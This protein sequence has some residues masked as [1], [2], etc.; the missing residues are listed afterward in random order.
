MLQRIT[1]VFRRDKHGALKIVHIHNSMPFDA[2]KSDELF[3]MTTAKEAF[4]RLQEQLSRQNRQI[5]LMLS[6]LPGGLMICRSDEHFTTK[7]LSPGLYRLLGYKS[8]EEYGEA[9]SGCCRGFI[10]PEDYDLMWNQVTQALAH[11]DSYS[12]E[13]RVRRKDGSVLWVME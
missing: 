2:L 6:Q 13:Y 10:L 4:R 9:C 7:W 8:P 11:G 1:F 3:P 5:E 12:V